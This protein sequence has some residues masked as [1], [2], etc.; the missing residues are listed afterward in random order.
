MEL[1]GAVCPRQKR[2]DVEGSSELEAYVQ[3]S[4]LDEK[5]CCR[6]RR[7]VVSPSLTRLDAEAREWEEESLGTE[8]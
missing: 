1:A 2:G 8:S 5:C 3:W 6:H 4:Q 7:H